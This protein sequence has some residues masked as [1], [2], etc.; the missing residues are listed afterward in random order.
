MAAT[1][2]QT[3]ALLFPLTEDGS[4]LAKEMAVTPLMKGQVARY[5]LIESDEDD[6]NRTDMEGKFHLKKTPGYTMVGKKDIYDPIN[7]RTVTILNKSITKR[8]KTPMGEMTSSRPESIKFMSDSPIVE[9]QWDEPEK[10]AFLERANENRD[11]P[12][13]RVRGIKPKYYRIDSKKRLANDIE[14]ADF[15]AAAIHWVWYEANYVDLKACA[16]YANKVNPELKIKTDYTNSQAEEGLGTLKR[17]LF[18]LAKKDP[19]TVIKGSTK[20]ESKMKM[21]LQE[22]ERLQIILFSDAK[23][24]KADSKLANS[25]IHNDTDLTTICTVDPGK[26]KHEALLEFISKDPKGKDHYTKIVE[27]LTKFVS[28][29]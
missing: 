28:P 16:D 12:F 11:N 15:E 9:V 8:F 18:D 17:I 7:G 5:K 13:R 24:V 23:K 21:Q 27:T 10:Y 20:I 29:R 14:K 19:Q 1:Q 4:T 6:P 2:T 25:W 22:A 3:S 26:N